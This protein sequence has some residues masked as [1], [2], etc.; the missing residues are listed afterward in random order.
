MTGVLWGAGGGEDDDGQSSDRRSWL[1]GD[2]SLISHVGPVH[3]SRGGSAPV[4]LVAAKPKRNE[5]LTASIATRHTN[6]SLSSPWRRTRRRGERSGAGHHCG[7]R[8][9]RR[10]R[11]PK[12]RHACRRHGQRLAEPPFVSAEV[13]GV[14][15]PDA[16]GSLPR[17]AGSGTVFHVVE[18][19]PMSPSLH[20]PDW[21]WVRP[22]WR[23]GCK[24]R[25]ACRELMMGMLR[26]R[27]WRGWARGS[28]RV[29]RRPRR[30]RGWACG[31]WGCRGL[32]GK[33]SMVFCKLVERLRGG[34]ESP[35]SG[36]CIPR[37]WDWR[38]VSCRGF[39]S[40]CCLV[41]T[42]AVKQSWELERG[43]RLPSTAP[44]RCIS[45]RRLGGR[46]H[47][48]NSTAVSL[49]RV[50][51]GVQRWGWT[52]DPSLAIGIRPGGQLSILF[53]KHLLSW[54]RKQTHGWAPG[55]GVDKRFK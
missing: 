26:Q 46:L 45:S 18:E 15:Q 38:R 41:V 13:S 55:T 29:G 23:C 8:R 1:S 9:Q 10:Q 16:E 4:E 37:S 51:S 50:R 6:N 2:H 43:F 36:L 19:R 52:M 47:R 21:A 49:A 22:L 12:N 53:P 34:L 11:R 32:D 44:K 35:R 25:R 42:E 17:Q 20:V 33:Q 7:W 40:A 30:S 39:G 48:E 31:R 54:R 27:G 5:T 24:P 28:G 14:V 3:V